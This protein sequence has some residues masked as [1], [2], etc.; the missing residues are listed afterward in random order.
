MA[1]YVVIP[2]VPN[3]ETLKT[4]IAAMPEDQVFTLTNNAGWLISFS[5]LADELSK[6][7]GLP[8]DKKNLASS[9]KFL[10]TEMGNYYGYGA[11]DM[12]NWIAN[13]KGS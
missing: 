4:S 3:V 5:G 10:V 8:A 2:L 6:K 7:L 11:R 12:W 13:H 9:P 1:I